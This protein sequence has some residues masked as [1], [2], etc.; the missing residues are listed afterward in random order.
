RSSL[1]KNISLP[2]KLIKSFFQVRKM[3]GSFKPDAVIGVGGYSSF[4][5]L[6]VAQSKNIPSFIH[7][8][9]SFAGK[10]NQLLGKKATAI[11]TA[12]DGIEIFFPVEKV[13]ITGN[14][15]R[16]SLIAY[17]GSK[18]EAV[19][20]FGLDARKQTVLSIGGSLGAQSINEAIADQIDA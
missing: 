19:S 1:I 4:P 3:I 8:S 20:F 15:I 7:E 9:N 14:P 2:F 17:T 5:V 13:E 10:S 6:R 11:F 18:A 16:Q 12:T